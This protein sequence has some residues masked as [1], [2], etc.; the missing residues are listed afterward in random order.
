MASDET[1]G[2]RVV[3]TL[4]RVH[5]RYDETAAGIRTYV[6]AAVTAIEVVLALALFAMLALWFVR[7]LG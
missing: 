3:E 7:Y 6:P 2:T 1:I 5:E 4:G